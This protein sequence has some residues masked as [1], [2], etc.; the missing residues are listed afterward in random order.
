MAIISCFH[1]F[2]QFL[3]LSVIC[4]NFVACWTM[5]T[6]AA[7]NPTS[8]EE[9]I[10]QRIN[11][12]QNGKLR[13]DSHPRTPLT[14][15]MPPPP[16]PLASPSASSSQANVEGDIDIENNNTEEIPQPSTSAQ[17]IHENYHKP[18]TAAEGDEEKVNIRTHSSEKR[19][20]S[21]GS[22]ASKAI[23]NSISDRPMSLKNLQEMVRYTWVANISIFRLQKK[24]SEVRKLTKPF[25]TLFL[26][27]F[28]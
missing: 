11:A 3:T 18:S 28:L 10:Q 8:L 6:R 4:L 9:Q 5:A 2:T 25:S 23:S 12:M 19:P 26:K 17:P 16:P 14:T 24:E 21:S 13:R 7:L 22:H 1:T 27:E 15:T 20:G